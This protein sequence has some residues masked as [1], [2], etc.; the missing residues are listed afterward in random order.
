MK[1]AGRLLL[2]NRSG[3]VTAAADALRFDPATEIVI[4]FTAATDYNLEIMTFD[5][6][7]D[8]G[9]NAD[10]ILAKAEGKEG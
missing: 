6:S 8:S 2:K 7:M 10:A 9:R 4:L 5:R 1:F 3:T